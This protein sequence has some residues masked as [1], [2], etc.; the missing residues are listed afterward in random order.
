MSRS[1]VEERLDKKIAA[2]AM[3]LG[4]H[5]SGVETVNVKKVVK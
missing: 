4:T 1:G 3:G 2:S 5:W